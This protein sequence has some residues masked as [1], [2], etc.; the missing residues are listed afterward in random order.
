AGSGMVYLA[1]KQSH[2]M[3]NDQMVDHIVEQVEARAAQI[4]AAEKQA[5]D[6]EATAAE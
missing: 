2:K 1:G 3:S 6:A 5:A 4:E